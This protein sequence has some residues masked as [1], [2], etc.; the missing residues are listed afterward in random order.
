LLDFSKISVI[1]VVDSLNKFN[2]V[3]EIMSKPRKE[4]RVRIDDKEAVELLN[5]YLRGSSGAKV[6]ITRAVID[7]LERLK[8]YEQF[9]L[10]SSLAQV[11]VEEVQSV[12]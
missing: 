1:L 12:E 8:Q 10:R 7:H 9:D 11:P 2:K 5:W 3:E 4:F 6:I